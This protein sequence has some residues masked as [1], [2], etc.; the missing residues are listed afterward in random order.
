MTE[1]YDICIRV[2]ETMFTFDDGLGLTTRLGILI[3]FERVE[4]CFQTVLDDFNIHISRM[5]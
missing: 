2:N 1:C 3:C 4:V 5:K